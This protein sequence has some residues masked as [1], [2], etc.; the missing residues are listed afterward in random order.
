MEYNLGYL[1]LASSVER[2]PSGIK[3][4]PVNQTSVSNNN[5]MPETGEFSRETGNF[6]SISALGS[7]EGRYLSRAS[8]QYL[9]VWQILS[10]EREIRDGKSWQ[11]H[12]LTDWVL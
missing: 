9:S 7:R 2:F 5:C 10:T 12:L 6:A 1:S 8:S 11:L 4:K 3:Y